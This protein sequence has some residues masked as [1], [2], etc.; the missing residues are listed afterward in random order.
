MGGVTWQ[1][2]RGCLRAQGPVGSGSPAMPHRGSAGSGQL[3]AT[4]VFISRAGPGV[5]PSHSRQLLHDAQ[6][7]FDP[8][9]TL[10]RTG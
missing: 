1:E 2:D 4:A 7:T 8:L 10:E 9:Q 3:L 5:V 6:Y